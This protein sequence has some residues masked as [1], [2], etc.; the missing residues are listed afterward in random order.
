MVQM[1]AAAKQYVDRV[2]ARYTECAA[3]RDRGVV[4]FVTS[5]LETATFATRFLRPDC[6]RFDFDS[7]LAG[8]IV[9]WRTRDGARSWR[10]A[11]GEATSYPSLEAALRMFGG[12]SLGV[13]GIVPPLLMPHE[14]EFDRV[15]R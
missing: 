2:R 5:Q 13:V 10:S 8:R 7:P 9:I 11:G 6:F 14:L 1:D 15:G 12:I 3:Y 4:S